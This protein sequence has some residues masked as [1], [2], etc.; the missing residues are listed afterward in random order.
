MDATL[1]LGTVAETITVTREV[2]TVDTVNIAVR[3]VLPQE[4]LD[5]LPL[6]ELDFRVSGSYD[7]SGMRLQP[8]VDLFDVFNASTVLGA[9]ARYGPGV[10]E[11]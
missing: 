11:T 8:N 5:A 7:V 6:G 1:S 10:G 4:E 2:S 3:E 9:N